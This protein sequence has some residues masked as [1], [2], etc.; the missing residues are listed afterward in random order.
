MPANTTHGYPY[1]LGTDRV[2]DGDD[3][4]HNL[5]SAVDEKLRVTASGSINVTL[6][7]GNASASTVV[8][9]PSGRFTDPPAVVATVNGGPTAYYAGT[10]TQTATGVT[11]FAVRRDG[12]NVG[13]TVTVPVSWFA[14]AIS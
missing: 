7:A 4:I 3:A 2:M 13:S 1:P 10:T 14:D 11:V 8:T 9:F 6:T 5:A 12:T